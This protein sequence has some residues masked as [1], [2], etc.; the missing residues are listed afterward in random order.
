MRVPRD[1]R[2]QVRCGGARSK[3]EASGEG[4]GWARDACGGG[5]GERS[6]GGGG[7]GGEGQRI[8]GAGGAS[9]T[10]IRFGGQSIRFS[11]G[12]PIARLRLGP[13]IHAVTSSI[14]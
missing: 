14:K 7:R 6:G 11:A 3:R 8:G 5:K 12:T 2:E 1:R 9:G 4:C 13:E 10:G